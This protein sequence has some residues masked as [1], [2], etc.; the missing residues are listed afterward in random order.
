MQAQK[1]FEDFRAGQ[2]SRYKVL[3]GHVEAVQARFLQAITAMDDR[4]RLVIE[5]GFNGGHSAAAFL[6]A[7]PDVRVVSFDIE[8][9]DYVREAKALIDELFPGRHT[10]I[11]GDSRLT[12]PE[13]SRANRTVSA[14]IAFIDG[15][16]YDDVPWSDATNLLNILRPGGL[17][18]LDDIDY[19]E[20]GRAWKR[21]QEEGLVEALGSCEGQERPWAVARK[22]N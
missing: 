22:P 1:S 3:E 4:V 8:R 2:E 15:G 10:L 18:V 14:D 13:Y 19:P 11:F 16:Q 20:V 17:L 9:W 12:V 7:S 5:T 21:L 6:A